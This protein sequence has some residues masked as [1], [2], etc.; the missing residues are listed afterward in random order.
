MTPSFSFEVRGFFSLLLLGFG[1]LRSKVRG[2]WS[3]PSDVGAFALSPTSA[4]CFR[5]FSWIDSVSYDSSPWAFHSLI[6][7]TRSFEVRGPRSPGR[8][9]KLVDLEYFLSKLGLVVPSSYLLTYIRRHALLRTSATSKGHDPPELYI[10]RPDWLSISSWPVTFRALHCG[11]RQWIYKGCST[12]I[13]EENF[14]SLNE[15]SW[16]AIV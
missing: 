14:R 9:S 16:R 1:P 6:A 4:L 10:G 5:S 15:S 3:A 12:N 7:R 11:H 13:E 2:P 8:S